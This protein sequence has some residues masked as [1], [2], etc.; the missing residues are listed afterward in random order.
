M[1]TL[2][3]W[4]GMSAADQVMFDAMSSVEIDGPDEEPLRPSSRSQ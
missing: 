2:P 4:S 3:D 1:A